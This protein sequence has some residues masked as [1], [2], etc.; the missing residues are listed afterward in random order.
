MLNISNLEDVRS[1]HNSDYP[2]LVMTQ[3]PFNAYVFKDRSKN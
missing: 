1:K 3:I 2:I